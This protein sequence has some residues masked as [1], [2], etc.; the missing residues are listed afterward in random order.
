MNAGEHVQA[1]RL[2]RAHQLLHA[3]L[4]V[5]R[6]GQYDRQPLFH[7]RRETL[8]DAD[9][10]RRLELEPVGP[11]RRHLDGAL[12]GQVH[13]VDAARGEIGAERQGG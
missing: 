9:R 1:E 3:A 12:G 10:L 11:P 5:D 2:G 6:R 13:R 7:E 8:D 4:D